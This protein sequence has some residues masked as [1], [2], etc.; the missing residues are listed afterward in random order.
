MVYYMNKYIYKHNIIIKKNHLSRYLLR[1]VG[2]RRDRNRQNK[3]THPHEFHEKFDEPD[4]RQ[5]EKIE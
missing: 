4:Q 1:S 2:N 3:F 5:L